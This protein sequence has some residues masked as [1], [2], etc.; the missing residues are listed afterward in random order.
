[1][2]STDRKLWIVVIFL[3]ALLQQG[4]LHFILWYLAKHTHLVV[5]VTGQ[6]PRLHPVLL[7]EMIAQTHV[8]QS[9]TCSHVKSTHTLIHAYTNTRATCTH[10]HTHTHTHHTRTHPPTHTHTQGQTYYHSSWANSN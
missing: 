7:C 2:D 9:A 3:A 4:R 6:L 1:M 5:I 8:G 10:Q